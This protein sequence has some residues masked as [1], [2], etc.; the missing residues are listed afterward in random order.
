MVRDGRLEDAAIV[1]K[2]KVMP[3]KKFPSGKAGCARRAGWLTLSLAR[4]R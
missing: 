2:A 1:G 4:Y 3:D